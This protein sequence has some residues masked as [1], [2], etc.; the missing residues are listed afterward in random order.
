MPRLAPVTSATLPSSLPMCDASFSGVAIISM[1]EEPEVRV[2]EPDAVLAAG[3]LDLGV[4]DRAARLRDEAHAVVGGVVHVVAERQE[5][6]RDQAHA[7][8]LPEPAL[9]FLGRERLEGSDQELAQRLL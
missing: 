4:G 8:Q 5:A 6:V 1:M 3:L 2:H 7:V 9:A